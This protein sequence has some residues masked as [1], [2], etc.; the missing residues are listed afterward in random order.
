MQIQDKGQPLTDEERQVALETLESLSAMVRGF[1]GVLPPSREISVAQTQFETAF[2]WGAH[3][4][5]QAPGA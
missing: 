5:R 4:V 1:F 2:L 3:A